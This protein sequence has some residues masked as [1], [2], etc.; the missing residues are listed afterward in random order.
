MPKLIDKHLCRQ[1]WFDSHQ[2]RYESLVMFERVPRHYSFIC[3]EVP[4]VSL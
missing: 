1:L 3:L 4:P 2:D